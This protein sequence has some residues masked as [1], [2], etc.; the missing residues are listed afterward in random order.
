MVPIEIYMVL[1]FQTRSRSALSLPA[2][3][4]QAYLVGNAQQHGGQLKPVAPVP[5]WSPES[6]HRQVRRTSLLAAIP[7]NVEAY[8]EQMPKA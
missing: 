4:F 6:A 3:L 2:V 7:V 5:L 8:P 1:A